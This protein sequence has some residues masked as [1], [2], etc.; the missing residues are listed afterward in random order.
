[1][2]KKRVIILSTLL[3]SVF[4]SSV[5]QVNLQ[6]G[7]AIFSLPVFNWQDDKSRLNSIIALSYNSGSGLKVSDVASNVGQG[8]SLIAGGVITRL[9]AGLPDDQVARD[10]DGTDHDITKYPP[11]I[12]YATVPAWK[13]SPNALTKYPIY[14]KKNQ[15]Y[16]QHNVIAEDK[17]L[18]YFSF[19][20]NGKAG[21]FILDPTNIGTAQSL[22]DTKMKIT[23]QQDAGLQSQGIRTKITSFSIQDVDGLIYKFSIHGLTKVLKT[24]YCDENYNYKQRA[25]KFKNDKVYYQSGFDD[26]QFV[27]PWIINSWYLTEVEDA[28]THRKILFNYIIRNG[29]NAAGEDISANFAKKNY[30]IVSRKISVTKTP[31]LISVVYPDGHT[32]V[33]NYSS[34]ERVD[35]KSEFAVS[36]IDITYQGRFLS[37]HQLK[38]S[39]FILNRYGT[40]VT[41]NQKRVARLCLRSVKKIGVDLKEDSP[42]YIFDYYTGSSTPDD[43]VPPPFF[44]AKDIWGFYNGDNSKGFWNET[45]PLNTSINKIKNFNQLKGLCFMRNGVS[46]V[47]LN[48]K[49]GYAKN[50][51]LKQIIYPTGGTLTYQYEQNSG[52]LG[53]A[54]TNVGGVHVSQTSSTDGG[55]SNGCD[56]PIRTQ[57]NYVM[58][59]AGSASSLWGLEMPVNSNVSYTHYQPEIRQYKFSFLNGLRCDWKY[60]NPGILSKQQAT[61][62]IVPIV[63]E[64]IG[65]VLNIISYLNAIKEATSLNPNPVSLI[66]NVIVD[67]AEKLIG[68]IGDEARDFTNTVYYNYD[69]NGVSSLPT[70]FK[71]VEVVES[72]GTIGKTVQEFTSSDDYPIWEQTNPVFSAKQRFAPWAYG[73]PKL[74]TVYDVN[75][76]KI[77][78]TENLYSFENAKQ[79]IKPCYSNSN[80]RIAAPVPT[81]DTISGVPSY[82]VC[83]NSL[84]T[85]MYSKS[86]DKWTN[87]AV[88]N[89]T[90]LT[91]SNN[92]MK[93][94]FYGMYTGRTELVTSSERTYK[95][96]DPAQFVETV[97]SYTYNSDNY[98][99]NSIATSKSDG[100]TVSKYIKYSIDYSGGALTTLVNNNIVSLPVETYT[101][102]NNPGGISGVIS[103]SVTEFT[104]LTNGD[105]KPSRVLERRFN[106]P[107]NTS[108]F[109]QGPTGNNSALNFKGTQ[110]FT[111]DASGNLTGIKDEGNRSITNIY[112]YNDKYVTASVINA[113]PITDMPAYSSFETASF[114][115]WTFNGSPL[116]YSNIYS[117]T[118]SQSFLLGPSNSLSAP[119]NAGKSYILSVWSGASL[120]ITAGATLVKSVPG[121]NGFIY[122]EYE[123]P[124]GGSNV[125]VSA[126][127]GAVIDELRLYPKTARMRTVTYDPLI[128]K[129][130]ECDVNNRITYYEYDNLGRLRFVKDENKNIVKMYEYNN[131]S[132]AKQNGCP[133]TYYNHLISEV[134][135]KANCDAGFIGSDV[136][137]N[138]PANTY[139]STISQEDADEK[140]ENYLLTNGQN[141]ANA[142]GTCIQLYL[143]TLQS[144][145]FTTECEEGYIGGTIIYSVPAGR[146]SSTISQEEADQLAIDEI[147][148]NGEAYANEN[149]TCSIDPDPHW[150]W[151]EGEPTYCGNVGG[152]PHQ[153]VLATDISPNSA[154][155]G[156]TQWMDAGVQDACPT[157]T[158]CNTAIAQN[159]QRDNCP[160]NYTGSLVF[161]NVAAG[162]YCS[163]I[164]QADA[165]AQAQTYA[166]NY[167]NQNGT[168]TQTTFCNTEISQNIQRNNCTSGAI[169]SFVFVTV[170]ADTYCSTINQADANN[171]AMAYA[172][173]SANQ[174]GTC[175]F[176]N[177]AKSA[178]AVKSNCTYSSSY[179][180][181]VTGNSVVYTI[182]AGTF[183]SAI[184]QANADAQAQTAA[185]NGV[186]AYANSVNACTW[187]SAAVTVS[188]VKNDCPAPATGTT[189]YYILPAGSYTSTISDAN[190]FTL[191]YNAATAGS[192]IYANANGSCIYWNTVQSASF[193]KNNC[194][195]GGTGSSVPY[196][197]AANTYS[198]STQ[199]EANNLAINAL[200][201]LG[202]ANAN[203]NGTCTYCNTLLSQNFTR[204]NCPQGYTGSTVTYAV[205]PCTFTS[206]IS[207][208]DANAQAQ[209]YIT[210]NGQGYANET[211]ICTQTPFWNVTKSA[212]ATKTNCTYSSAYASSVTGNSVL[213]TIPAGTYSSLISQ[214]DAD[215]QAQTA[216]DNGAQA[217]ANASN[218]CTWYSAAVT[219]GKQKND[220]APPGTG[221]WVYYSL[222]A[223]TYSS[224]VSDADAFMQAYNAALAVMTQTYANANGSCV[225]WN[226][227]QSGSFTKNDCGIGGTPGPAI[228]YT[229]AANTYTGSTQEEANNTA[230]TILNYLGQANANANGTCT[231]CNE[232]MT[233]YFTRNDCPTGYTG[234]TVPF[235]V[236]SCT[237]TSTISVA[238]A[239]A[240][241]QAYI[242]ATGQGNANETGTCTPTGCSTSNCNGEGYKC[243]NSV[244]E[245]GIK[246]YT[247][248]YWDSSMGQYVCVYHYEY[249]DGSWT[250][251]YYEY[252]NRPCAIR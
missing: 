154:S 232:S 176:W 100:G 220:C 84:V 9:Q 222:P 201:S 226:T 67:I 136:I 137:F 129:T 32:A 71:R 23:F 248:S 173:N 106:Q 174:N 62:I 202:Q 157:I 165:D 64:S 193:T 143:N 89:P 147:E 42:P 121:I 98:E 8:W 215:A 58:N 74:T 133:V 199:A 117:I 69:F 22:G 4:L 126:S 243:V 207:Q 140:A 13:G 170:P 141:Y 229:I 118:G 36:S 40:P 211:G 249:S 233:Q 180:S 61:S 213:Y 70:Q 6:T 234:S 238:D 115:G 109:Y 26:G 206:T 239:N 37:Q 148:A 241:A 114:G 92:D 183:S 51:L 85:K 190:A 127:N 188:A 142:N 178:S 107:T 56:N 79:I 134:F 203:T 236:L 104:Q 168:C 31:E 159:I 53:G 210:A 123:I 231:Y 163:T 167:A 44:Y 105:I 21:M 43:F 1:M 252:N 72:P 103:E 93:V 216:A 185:N 192:Q 113:D 191:A 177:V 171:Q 155:Y 33:I 150:V 29:S 16:A 11:G 135:T 146:Y 179:A 160:Q 41:E 197:I 108:S 221:T 204:N 99:V 166:Q 187:Y 209:V 30:A 96:N 122:Y 175:L 63:L 38:T 214:A 86:S 46:G 39:Y 90:Y 95:T 28:L 244:C 87:P 91:A 169:G 212:P 246:I 101:S 225:Y 130:S 102:V 88:Y 25:P 3:F 7:S 54:T 227:E 18:D 138:V 145:S 83:C 242:N 50:G 162:T 181:S 240:K 119:L 151:E 20:F 124:Q 80:L 184:S 245:L 27:N 218:A 73:L 14:G 5:A 139:S 60:K 78:Q 205:Q 94:D 2:S 10:G 224:T 250:Q 45:I 120:S 24:E 59:G 65:T 55:Y 196:T 52:V 208:A 19:Q 198:G 195:T 200:N 235:T 172:Q 75:G 34:K 131:I 247:D 77:K 164:S 251:D 76:K 15:L 81:C 217:N 110:T 230:I 161:V 68:C 112:D 194:G 223:G 153:F 228:P 219:V 12:L 149:G 17:Q 47:Y 237:Y 132:A 66:I 189:V 35:L 128:G 97:T 111:Y 48:P 144:Q 82:I 156:Q 116:S 182:P 57:Y 158:Y 49:P 125:T 186:Q 152:I